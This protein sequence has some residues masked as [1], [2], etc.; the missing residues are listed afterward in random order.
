MTSGQRELAENA[1]PRLGRGVR[2]KHDDIRDRWTLLA[3]ERI[4]KLDGVAVEIIK[5]VDGKADLGMIV[6]DLATTF[7]AERDQILADVREF[8]S[9]LMERRAVDP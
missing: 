7:D 6:D 4:F 9:D 5:R 3:P 8:L 1:V 2:L